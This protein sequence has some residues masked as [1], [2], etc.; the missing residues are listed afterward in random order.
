MSAVAFAPVLVFMLVVAAVIA[1]VSAIFIGAL[2]PRFEVSVRRRIRRAIADALSGYTGSSN[3]ERLESVFLRRHAWKLLDECS[4]VADTIELPDAGR[5]ALEGLLVGLCIDKKLERDLRSRKRSVRARAAAYLGFFTDMRVSMVRR[6]EAEPSHVVRLLLIY[7]LVEAGVTSAIP[8]IIDSLKDAPQRYQRAVWGLVAEFGHD[9]EEFVPLLI[10]RRE[11]EIQMLLIHLA[12]RYCSAL[13]GKHIEELTRSPDLDIARSAFRVLSSTRAASLDHRRYLVHEDFLIRNLT[14]ESLGSI[15]R[16]ESLALIFDRLDDP[17]I[18]K[19]AVMALNS[20]IRARPNYLRIVMYRCLNE[21]KLNAKYALADVLGNYVEYLAGKLD[22][23]DAGIAERVLLE[24]AR[25]GKVNEIVNF[26]NRNGNAA[27]EG[28]IVRILK[29]LCGKDPALAGKLRARADP[30]ILTALGIEGLADK[31]ERTKRLERTDLPLLLAFLFFGGFLVPAVCLAVAGL[32]A[33]ARTAQSIEGFFRLFSG[34]F[35]YA[36]ALYSGTLSIL[37]L[38][39]LFNSIRDVRRQARIGALLRQSFLFKENM[40]PSVSIISPAYN[41]E[42]TIVESV[43]ALFNLHYPDY[44]IIVVNDGSTDKTLE[45]LIGYFELERTEV[46]IHGYLRTQ[47]IRGVYANKRYP[48]LLVVDKANGGKAD[49]LNA[50]INIARKEYFSGI[51]A[52][53]LLERDAL[54]NLA[55]LFLFSEHEVTAAGGNILPVNGCSVRKGTLLSTRIPRG[56]LARFQTVEYIRAFMAGRVGWASLKLLLIISGAFGVFHRRSVINAHGYLTQSEHYVKDTVGE[57]MEL[58]VRLSRMKHE[59]KTPFSIVYAYNA[60][61]WTEIPE[62][63]AIF[64]SQRDRWQR[65]LIDIV[66]FHSRT[67][68]NPTYGRM[69]LFGMPYFLIFEILG[70]WLEIE[71][72]TVFVLSLLLGWLSLPMLMLV[73][74]STIG[75]GFLV[76]AVSISL[77]EYGKAYFPLRD[78]ILL[79]LYAVAESFG[80]RQVFNFMRVR[81]FVHMLSKKQGWGKME[82]RGWDTA[83]KNI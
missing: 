8:T 51:D 27:I 32:E 5:R 17:V 78:K 15:P 81:G 69:G 30:R 42:L 37:Y 43:N 73:T 50:G 28:K 70:P 44:E 75:L 47:E 64:A 3:D 34:A 41:E 25:F 54:L 58:V 56:H 55:G 45:R 72:F 1:A 79:L 36:F 14:A 22:S 83:S 9:M 82:R 40:L 2:R 38:F 68:F 52:D 48:E 13:L 11:K 49:S 33:G 21:R 35:N 6:L 61:C 46:F 24:L 39:L 16:T 63:T 26:L 57:D 12:G 4:R 71:G 7:G 59:D 20:L 31:R 66:S 10:P 76:S 53:S 62:R 77:V 18:R 67:L 65:G 80:V 23:P 19:S 74:A 29:F 60:N